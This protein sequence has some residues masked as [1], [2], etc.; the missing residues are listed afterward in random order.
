[1]GLDPTIH[2]PAVMT[3]AMLCLMLIILPEAAARQIHYGAVDDPG[4]LK[5]DR[6]EWN[7]EK[8]VARQC[9]RDLL[10]GTGDPGIQAE[11]SW[12]LGDIK[13]ANS[14]FQS[15]VK[16]MPD[17][18]RVRLRWGDLFMETYQYQEALD[19]FSEALEL[20]PANDFARVGASRALLERFE[21]D[22]VKNLVPVLENDD[23]AA[24]ASLQAR[25]LLARMAIESTDVD[26]AL[27]IL[28][29]AG[30]IAAEA[31]LPKLEVYALY[32][33]I[34]LLDGQTTSV[35]TQKALDENPYFGDIYA[36]PGYFF[37]I[38]RRYREAAGLY[39]QAVEVQADHWIAHMELG[40]NLLRDNQVT[41]ARQHLQTAYAGDPYNP[42]TVN[43]LRL[44]DT[45]DEYD[46][47]NLPETPPPDGFPRLT[48]RLHK[49]ESDV[50]ISYAE[51]LAEKGLAEFSSRYRFEP[52]EPVI[53]EIY[54]NHEDFVVRTIGMP[55]V[56]ILGATFGYLFAMDSPSDHP[57][58]E[59]HW[60]T[61]LWHEMAHVFTL[62][63]T[64]H[65]IPRWF[66]E[67]ISVF[68][69]WRY[70]PIKGIRIPVN[71][72]E[73]M[74]E[75]K[76]LPVAD[77]DSGFIRPTYDEQ[78]IVSYM[79][80]GLV[81]EYID[82][83]H[84]FEKIIELLA[85]FKHSTDTG[86]AIEKV[87]GVT[88]VTFD[89]GFDAFVESEFG[90]VINQLPAWKDLHQTS[91]KQFAESDWDGAI[92]SAEQAINIFPEYVESDSPYLVLARAYAKTGNDD[93]DFD[94]LMRFWQRGGYTPEAVWELAGKLYQRKRIE[95]AITVL[96]SVNYVAPFD[97]DLHITLG[98]WSLEAGRAEQALNEYEIV[99]AMRPHDLAA[100]HYRVAHANHL[101]DRKDVV[102]KH[103]LSALE[104]APHYRPAQKLLL[105]TTQTMQQKQ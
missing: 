21:S 98:D 99:L 53:I 52:K 35:W 6:L 36:V 86:Q 91:I 70:G 48:F 8:Q 61:T 74:A 1:M 26:Q 39:K 95:E 32:A 105:E 18:A 90:K 23:A 51:Q 24:G 13:S 25:L 72:Y 94:T 41:L 16:M 67:G 77:L 82:R 9:Y 56:G 85:E 15:A 101:L 78:V 33:S 30:S 81:C 83:H 42:K 11:I 47:I 69:E 4:L 80:A 65:L 31:D 14:L 19:L 71:V 66:S 17:S 92:A 46:L 102:R 87:L 79:Q 20:D 22:A 3:A 49:D 50:L 75:D 10:Q 84:G 93:G 64:N 45:F 104:I 37:W 43:T 59:Y 2:S 96:N 27:Q 68:E 12:A 7:G 97:V 76:F 54:P 38:S 73:A 40:I 5:C 63:T 55:G 100:A 44:L 62:E 28:E 34:D 88:P 103:L 58:K 89:R 57:D 29:E 60:G